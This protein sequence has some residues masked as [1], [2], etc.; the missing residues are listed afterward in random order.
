MSFNGNEGSAITLTEAS[1]LTANYRATIS[2]GDRLALFV[3]RNRL[4]D[5]LN[6]SG[7]MGVRIYFG[8]DKNGQQELVLV[9]AESNEDDME[10]GVII[11]SLLPCPQR[12]SAPNRLNT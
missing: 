4:L 9:G 6:Q 2:P 8:I 12:C 11:D 7:C 3:G 5:I 1:D 10:K